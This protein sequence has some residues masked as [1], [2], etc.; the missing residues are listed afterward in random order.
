MLS[1]VTEVLVLEGAMLSVN[2][3]L[4]AACMVSQRYSVNRLD[5]SGLKSLETISTSCRR[6][7]IVCKTTGGPVVAASFAICVAVWP[8]DSEP[9][10]DAKSGGLSLDFSASLMDFDV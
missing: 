6:S 9:C 2:V 8:G 3:V 7:K 4:E 10:S 1:G 5:A